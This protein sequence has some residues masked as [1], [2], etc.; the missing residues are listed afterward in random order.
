MSRQL[1]VRTFALGLLLATAGMARGQWGELLVRFT[2]ERYVA[3][4][5]LSVS[6]EDPACRR[7][8]RHDESLRIDPKS[9]GVADVFVWLAGTP[10][11]VHPS[12]R[13]S[14]NKPIE[15]RQRECRFEPHLVAV[16]CGQELLIRNLDE[17][18]HNVS[19][20]SFDNP[21]FSNVL[22]SSYRY[23]HRFVQPEAIPFKANCNIHPWMS[24]YLLV[25][26]HPYMAISDPQGRA[27]LKNLPAGRQRIRAWHEP[28]RIRGARIDG[29]ETNWPREGLVVE[30][31]DGGVFQLQVELSL[32]ELRGMSE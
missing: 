11:G 7:R 3:P 16:Q 25:L 24:A 19:F 17:T 14:R 12:F 8:P 1:G 27:V 9:L 2:T 30:I 6:G 18:G 4:A 32:S 26:D 29:R 5:E 20:D 31:P 21:G 15:L 23:S 10:P 28:R 22:P 13:E